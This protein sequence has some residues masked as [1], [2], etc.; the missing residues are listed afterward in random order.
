MTL[1]MDRAQAFELLRRHTH[2]DSLLKHALCVEA[3]MRYL[4]ERWGEDAEWW[5]MVGLLHDLDFDEHPDR[6]C[7][8][9]PELLREAGFD[10]DFVRAVLSHGWGLCTDVEPR[11]RMEKAIYASDELTGLVTACALMRPSKSVM[12]METKS[13]M[14]KFKTP[15]FAASINR[16]VIKNGA[17][18][19]G[20]SVDELA[21][22]VILALRAI[23]DDI[24][25]GMAS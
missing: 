12:D 20:L 18:L 2:S 14:K 24:G 6:H 15:A 16:E 19:L 23:A 7:Q 17:E 4:A 10:E 25:L 8:V 13:V 22:M 3:T 11:H 9:T 1:P 21:G 5:G